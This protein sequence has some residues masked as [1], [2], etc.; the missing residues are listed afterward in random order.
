MKF[1]T[2]VLCAFAVFLFVGSMAVSGVNAYISTAS[3]STDQMIPAETYG[4]DRRNEAVS[5]L[6][7]TEFSDLDV[8]GEWDNTMSSMIGS[9][10][11][12]FTYD[13]LTDYTQLGSIID[14]YDILLITEMENGNY[15]DADN[16]VGVWDNILP[17]YVENGGIVICM[18]FNSGSESLGTAAQILNGTGLMELYNPET[19]YTHQWNLVNTSDALARNL[20]ADWL[21]SSGSVSFDT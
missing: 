1:E 11:G 16:V 4:D 13:N 7:Y 12:K 18:P 6:I 17:S 2:K 20:P 19:A 14:E 10:E 5:I 21:S 3:V 8:D 15:T 9:L